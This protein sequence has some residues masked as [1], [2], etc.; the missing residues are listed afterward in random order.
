MRGA[1]VDPSGNTATGSFFGTA[2]FDPG[3]RGHP[4]RR[5]AVW[6]LDTSGNYVC[7]T[8]T[9]NARIGIRIDNVEASTPPARAAF[10]RP[11]S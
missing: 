9:G 7:A 1:A 10:R 2:D 6:K 3:R 5:E 8:L 11:T 4:D